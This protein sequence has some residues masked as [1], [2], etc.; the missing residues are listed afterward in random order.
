MPEGQPED[1]PAIDTQWHTRFL[2]D[3]KKW[4]RTAVQNEQIA[5][6]MMG[7]SHYVK[8]NGKTDPWGFM[9][10]ASKDGECLQY[11]APDLT[12]V[13][14]TDEDVERVFRC[15]ACGQH[16]LD[17]NDIEPPASKKAQAQKRAANPNVA[18]ARAAV[19]AST[20]VQNL[21]REDAAS[22][23][24]V[25]LPSQPLDPNMLPEDQDPFI[26]A[27]GR[28]R[29]TRASAPRPAAPAPLPRAAPPPAAPLP[30]T[31]PPT[32]AP[33]DGLSNEDFKMEIDRMMK[34]LPEDTDAN[35]ADAFKQ[36]V[37]RMVKQANAR[38][39]EKA[40]RAQEKAT[41]HAPPAVED[42]DAEEARLLAQLEAVRAKKAAGASKSPGV[43]IS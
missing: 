9:R 42:A 11:K 24:A 29:T 6:A 28:A 18:R 21:P 25:P 3:K 33:E 31:P 13:E 1:G 23:V 19:E 5:R 38:A 37:E 2:D 35:S 40:T 20:P 43:A 15:K 34:A 10:G 22:D 39:Q 8:E 36:E 32:A 26:V 30:T 17:H 7:T 4:K 14:F 16:F 12:K 27:A 41:K